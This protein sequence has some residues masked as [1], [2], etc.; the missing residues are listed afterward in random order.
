MNIPEHTTVEHLEEFVLKPDSEPHIIYV[1]ATDDGYRPYLIPVLQ[2]VTEAIDGKIDILLV[3]A[4]KDEFYSFCSSAQVLLFPTILFFRK[5]KLATTVAGFIPKEQL[6]SIARDASEPTTA[7]KVME[8][9]R[10]AAEAQRKAER[11]E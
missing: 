3:D 11:K 9:A 5:G 1:T 2:E 10:E 6:I 8:L 4:E 7:E